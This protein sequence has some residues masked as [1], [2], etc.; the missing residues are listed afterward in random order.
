MAF[1]PISALDTWFKSSKYYKYS[2]G[3][4]RASALILNQNPFFEIVL[5]EKPIKIVESIQT[6]I[7][8]S[9]RTSLMFFLILNRSNNEKFTLPAATDEQYGHIFCIWRF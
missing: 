5:I 3:L 2:S 6:I 8:S 7:G 9:Y 1:G 4:K